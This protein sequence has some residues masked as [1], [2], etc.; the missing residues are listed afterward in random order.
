MSNPHPH[1]PDTNNTLHANPETAAEALH[2][3]VDRRLLL[4][5]LAGVAGVAALANLTKA[6][7]LTPPGGPVSSTPGPEPR[8]A[9]NAQNTPGS[10]AALFVISQPGSYYL[11][12]NV[13]GVLGKHGIQI[14]SGNVTLDLNG[15]SLE[16]VAGALDGIIV[17]LSN[18][19]T[20]CNGVVRN[21][22]GA[23]VSLTNS[24]SDGIVRNI[25]SA[26]NGTVGI[27]VT[28]RTQ[29]LGCV[30]ANNPTAG[31]QAEVACR[32]TDCIVSGNGRGIEVNDSC[33]VARCTV[34]NNSAEGIRAVI[35]CSISDNIVR[36]APIGIRLT[37]SSAIGVN[38]VERNNVVSCSTSYLVN[39]S[40]NF[41]A[42]NTSGLAA[43]SHW[44]IAAG[45]YINVVVA[46]GTAAFN[47]GSG[48]TPVS[49]TTNDPYLNFTVA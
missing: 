33:T 21:W 42:G 30:V 17:S 6:G 4:T 34:T 24:S 8:I 16:G 37:G 25:N 49:G 44:N 38:R 40:F 9:V 5:G 19:V 7:P 12:G 31:I 11:T 47:A 15:F 27:A 36:V 23:G 1:V 18:N 2:P 32:I 10:P 13:K 35:A 28:N 41:L 29:V 22:P 26:S 46:S 45:N 3:A 43:I 39:S 20:I 48:G 14:T